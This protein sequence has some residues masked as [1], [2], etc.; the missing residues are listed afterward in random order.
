[1]LL[2]FSLVLTACGG[3]GE[4][5]SESTEEETIE[6]VVVNEETEPQEGTSEEQILT[7]SLGAEPDSL[8]VAKATDIY[9]LKVAEQITEPLVIKEVE[10]DEDVIK[11][12]VAESW[13]VSDDGLV[14]TFKLRE[15]AK[16]SDGEPVTAQ[17][18]VYGMGRFVDPDT[19][20]P[21]SNN[22]K[23]IKNGAIIPLGEAEVEDL[24]A[25][26]LDDHTLEI[27]LE[28]PVPYFLDLLSDQ[29]YFPQR[30]DIVEEYGSSYG[31][32][33]GKTISNGPFMLDSWTH[34]SEVI[35]VKNPEYWD[36]EAVKL[37][38]L[39]MKIIPEENA[40]MGE[41]E[42]E[43]VDI[44]E[45]STAEWIDRLNAQDK[46]EF[47]YKPI[48][49]T[50][51]FFI[52]HDTEYFQNDKIRKAFTIAIDREEISTVINQNLTMPAYGWVPPTN[53]IDGINFREAAGEPVQDLIDENPDPRALFIEGLEELGKDPDPSKVNIE[54]MYSDTMDK[55]FFEYFQQVYKD[56][57]GINIILDPTE[58]PVL[59]ERN[60]QLDYEV[61]YKTKGGTTDPS[62]FLEIWQT[63][64]KTIPLAWNDEEYDA[65]VN[66]AAQSM[67]SELRIKNYTEAERMFLY[68]DCAI[69]PISYQTS[70]IFVQPY[71]KGVQFP[72]QGSILYK[73]AYI[74]R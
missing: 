56:V 62:S 3:N 18:F 53:E 72:M 12:A 22:L 7:I 63:G 23:H 33:A 65:L 17:D 8:D 16:W 34:N 68:E 41:F 73:Y 40:L 46:Y 9:C 11:P 19:A 70:N 36:S 50:G 21:S 67:D 66:E 58:W 30:Q 4:E 20:S 42:N 59:Q 27:T 48:N 25:I 39:N 60:R 10:N 28:Y 2:V 44:V 26:A 51:Y 47:R 14:W 69:T 71:V 54:L 64:N 6:E 61:G 31:T 29:E 55:E 43:G 52:N 32:D 35:L 13:E 5:T 38:E 74:Q 15:D 45:A 24:G 49:R 57:L 1:M 37:D